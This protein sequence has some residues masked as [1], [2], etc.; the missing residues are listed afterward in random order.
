MIKMKKNARTKK[1]N[2]KKENV[3]K[4]KRL[5]YVF[6]LLKLNHFLFNPSNSKLFY[7]VLKIQKIFF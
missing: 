3:F 1:L 2:Y 6:N 7:L 4:S 5:K